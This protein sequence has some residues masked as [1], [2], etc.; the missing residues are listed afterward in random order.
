MKTQTT[1]EILQ[2]VYDYQIITEKQMKLLLR[3][4]NN[5]EQMDLSCI[6]D[7]EIVLTSEHQKKGLDYLN[8]L[9][10]TPN[11][12]ERKNNPFGYREQKALETCEVIR[13]KGFYNASLYNQSKFYIP[14]YEVLG[15]GANFEYHMQG[16][17][18]NIVG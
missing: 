7:G 2:H 13:L 18:I 6:W 16:G 4:L 8:N 17:K 12:K 5:S 15:N 14:L 9:W 10:K 11:G 3:R 1:T